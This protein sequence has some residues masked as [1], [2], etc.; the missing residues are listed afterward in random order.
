MR[1]NPQKR[2]GASERDAEDVKRQSFFRVKP[3]VNEIIAMLKC[4]SCFLLL[5]FLFFLFFVCF[6]FPFM[7]AAVFLARLLFIHITCFCIAVCYSP[8]VYCVGLALL[9]EFLFY[10]L[11]VCMCVLCSVTIV[12]CI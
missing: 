9:L 2:L 6:F 12:L 4:I 5:R 11:N 10:F 8:A 7:L 3:A 1:R